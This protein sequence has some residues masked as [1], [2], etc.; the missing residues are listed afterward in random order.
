MSVIALRADAD[1]LL[2]SLSSPAP[3]FHYSP[4]FLE[5]MKEKGGENPAINEYGS[6]LSRIGYVC[7]ISFF[8]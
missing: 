7:I 8:K 5:R 1:H 6:G 2:P 3:Y 4:E